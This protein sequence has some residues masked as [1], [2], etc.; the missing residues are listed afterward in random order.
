MI[1]FQLIALPLIG[2]FF[3]LTLIRLVR[4][5]ENRR[6]A[7]FWLL[8]WAA[9]GAAVAFPNLTTVVAK[10]M[11]IDRGTDLVLYCAVLAGMVGFLFIY[12]RS[13]QLERQL[14]LLVRHMALDEAKTPDTHC[15]DAG[16]TPRQEDENRRMQ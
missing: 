13:R 7:L 1:F 11:G 10:F 6:F 3:G 14:T 15:P 5:R 9:A 4:A 2:L 16:D 8:I 12:R